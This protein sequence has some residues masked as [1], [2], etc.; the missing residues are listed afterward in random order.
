M[1]PWAEYFFIEQKNSVNN[2]A[3]LL[4]FL[5]PLIFYVLG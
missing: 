2:K 1:Y 5:E 4:L 3:P